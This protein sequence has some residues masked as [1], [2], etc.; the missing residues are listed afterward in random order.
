MKTAFKTFC[1]DDGGA[2]TIDWVVLAAAVL[3][4][5]MLVLVPVVFS[6]TSATQSV[7]DYVGGVTVG[8]SGN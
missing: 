4:L 8:Y 5:V 2:V 3:G 1:K 7:S 6:T